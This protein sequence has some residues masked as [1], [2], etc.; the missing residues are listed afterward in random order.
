MIYEMVDFPVP[1]CDISYVNT[2][3][4]D[5]DSYYDENTLRHNL[6]RVT[7]DMNLWFRENVTTDPMV[8]LVYM[9]TEFKEN[10]PNMG[11]HVDQN[12]QQFAIN[13]II[14]TGGENV[15]TCFYDKNKTLVTSHICEVGKWYLLEVAN[16]HDVLGITRNRK[17]LSI[18]S[19]IPLSYKRISQQE[20]LQ[21]LITGRKLKSL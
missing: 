19:Y 4:F 3:V 12:Y 21:R 11:L 13:Y 14:D 1:T 9:E 15:T 17:M 16:L 7:D 5:S 20:I 18:R 10:K 8:H 6:Y 2:I